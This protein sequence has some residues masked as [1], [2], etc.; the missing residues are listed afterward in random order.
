M[1]LHDSLHGQDSKSKK[2]TKMADFKN[3]KS[4]PLNI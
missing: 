1:K 3:Y 4:E 2:S